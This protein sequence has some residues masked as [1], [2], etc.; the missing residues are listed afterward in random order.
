MRLLMTMPSMNSLSPW[1]LRSHSI[2]FITILSALFARNCLCLL[3]DIAEKL[4]SV[5]NAR[6]ESVLRA[7]AFSVL[8][9]EL[10]KLSERG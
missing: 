10:P 9:V 3:R 1:L 4:L 7:K 2:W 8:L 5:S 6:S